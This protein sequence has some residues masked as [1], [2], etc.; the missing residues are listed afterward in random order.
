MAGAY[1]DGDVCFEGVLGEVYLA[2]LAVVVGHGFFYLVRD[3]AI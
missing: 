1:G 3:V 2:D